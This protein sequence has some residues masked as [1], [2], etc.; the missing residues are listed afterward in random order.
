MRLG[1][2]IAISG[3]LD[4]ASFAVVPQPAAHPA[5]NS[6]HGGEC[7]WSITR[8]RTV[9]RQD[10]RGILYRLSLLGGSAREGS[11]RI[12][13][14][15]QPHEAFIFCS[16]R[17]P[18]VILAVDGGWQVDVLDFVSGPPPVLESSFSLYVRT[19]HP[20]ADWAADGFARRFGYT[21]REESPEISLS[22]P[23]DIFNYAR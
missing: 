19:C 8:S 20:G 1:L 3:L 11:N 4:G 16:R 21:A 17:L 23:E 18:A 10:A 9:V 12:R 7:S 5:L 2:A 15:R 13:W 6:C 14:N 22:R